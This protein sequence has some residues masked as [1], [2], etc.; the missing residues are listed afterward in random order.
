MVKSG[1]SFY[2]H[3]H[4][5]VTRGLSPLH[6]RQAPRHVS[7]LLD[8]RPRGPLDRDQPLRGRRA[9]PSNLHL[10]LGLTMQG[11][12]ASAFGAPR[13]PGTPSSNQ[14]AWSRA[15][16]LQG[17]EP[18]PRGCPGNGLAVGRGTHVSLPGKPPVLSRVSPET[19]WVKER[20]LEFSNKALGVPVQTSA[21]AWTTVPDSP[22]GATQ[23]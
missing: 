2:L 23:S 6:R 20:L 9:V 13:C 8:S 15:R 12:S 4:G 1:L 14:Q 10:T 5:D 16:A 7:A 19:P 18:R 11:R 21:T 22:H 17:Q 3:F